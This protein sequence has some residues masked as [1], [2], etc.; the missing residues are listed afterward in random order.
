MMAYNFVIETV[1]WEWSQL[2]VGVKGEKID[3]GDK[4]EVPGCVA[5][6]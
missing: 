5:P 6:H 4:C 1:P 2:W 3:N